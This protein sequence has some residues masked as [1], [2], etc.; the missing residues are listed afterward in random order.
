MS[1]LIENVMLNGEEVD[2]F[3]EGEIFKKI[4]KDLDVEASYTISGKDKAILPSFFNIHTHAAMTLLRGY[5]DD[6]ELYTWL[7]D[8]IWP[9]E[10]KLTP[11]DVYWGTKLACLEMIKTGT[12]FFVICIG[13]LKP[14]LMQWMRWDCGQRYPLHMWILKTQKK[15]N[16][17]EKE[18]QNFLTL[19]QRSHPV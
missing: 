10:R 4:G 5:A 16:I 9:F 12:T 15:G 17:L 13:M 2:I 1:I 8:H 6:M 14:L 19:L 3:I 18:I 11:D 7:N